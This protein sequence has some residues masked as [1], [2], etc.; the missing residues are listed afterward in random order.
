MQNRN[1][2]GGAEGRRTGGGRSKRAMTSL[3]F[4]LLGAVVTWCIDNVAGH[5]SFRDTVEGMRQ[6]TLDQRASRKSKGTGAVSVK[7]STDLSKPG[8]GVISEDDSWKEGLEK[9][10]Q[11]VAKDGAFAGRQVSRIDFRNF[12][13]GEWVTGVGTV[14]RVLDDDLIPPRHQ[15]FILADEF[16][17]TVLVAHNIDQAARILGLKAG[18]EV[19][20]RGEYKINDR[21]GVIHWTHPDS[22]RRRQGGWLRRK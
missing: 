3:L 10:D 20:F 13:D 6:A 19:A 18:D 8:G 14:R 22:S 21:G 9:A 11:G 5:G 17:N 2:L 16:G 15:R 4:L 12:R 7:K 1:L